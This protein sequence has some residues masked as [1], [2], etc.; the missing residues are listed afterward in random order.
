MLAPQVDVHGYVL[1]TANDTVTS[2]FCDGQIDFSYIQFKSAAAPAI[3]QM[4]PH[5]GAAFL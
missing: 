2:L 5:Y 3:R 1:H 4:W